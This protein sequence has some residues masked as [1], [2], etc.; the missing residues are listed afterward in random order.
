MV[1]FDEETVA[2]AGLEDWEVSNA[3]KGFR[4]F[5]AKVKLAAGWHLEAHA[6]RL[7]GQVVVF[8]VMV[9]DRRSENDPKRCWMSHAILPP[10]MLKVDDGLLGAVLGRHLARARNDGLADAWLDGINLIEQIK[11]KAS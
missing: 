9:D 7:Q 3:Q 2:A 8:T 5:F 10:F 11:R 4:E 6:R 1:S